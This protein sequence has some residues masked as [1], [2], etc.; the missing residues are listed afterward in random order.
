MKASIRKLKSKQSASKTSENVDFSQTLIKTTYFGSKNEWK[1]VDNRKLNLN[2][3]IS[4]RSES[5]DVHK[6]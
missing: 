6:F 1:K 3:S 5:V 4:K 2:Q